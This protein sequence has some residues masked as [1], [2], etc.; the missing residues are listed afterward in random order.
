MAVVRR[1]ITRRDIA[2]QAWAHTWPNDQLLLGSSRM[3]REFD[4]IV[5]GKKIPVWSNRGLSGIDGTIATSRGIA[6]GRAHAGLSG[7]TRVVLGDLAFLHDAGSL[8]LQ[9]SEQRSQQLQIFVV[10]D[11]GGS[12]FDSL[13]V[14]HTADRPAYERVIFT[15]ARA[16]VESLA[17]AYGWSYRRVVNHGDLLEALAEK[18]NQSVVECVVDRAG[19]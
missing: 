3:I 10:T 11:G 2:N 12:L 14:A 8:L 1:Q 5:P 13:E 6:A 18:S 19:P 9:T 16:E 4:S 15:P 7:V 17:A